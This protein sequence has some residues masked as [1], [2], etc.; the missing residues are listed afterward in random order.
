MGSK[1]YPKLEAF[2]VVQKLLEESAAAQSDKTRTI[3][4]SAIPDVLG[5]ALGTVIGGAASAAWIGGAAVAGTSGAAA[6]TS[7]L[8]GVGAVVGGGMMAGLAVA[9]LPVAALAVG[10][11]AFINYRNQAA[12][13]ERGQ[14]LYQEAL[15]QHQNLID[16]LKREANAT[17]ER[18]EYLES[19]VILLKDAIRRMKE[20]LG[21]HALAG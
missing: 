6:L 3:R 19:L 1:N 10:G 7:G 13:K 9:A 21:P 2:N 18:R 4:T 8:A 14:L 5:A 20:D 12:L 16:Q 15:R 17:R 11:Y